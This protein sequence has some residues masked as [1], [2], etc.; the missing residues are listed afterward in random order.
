MLHSL[1]TTHSSVLHKLKSNLADDAD[2][3][4]DADDTFNVSEVFDV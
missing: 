1:A 3:A 4:D 2:V